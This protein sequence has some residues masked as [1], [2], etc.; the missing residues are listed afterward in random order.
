MFLSIDEFVVC[1][2]KSGDFDPARMSGKQN[3]TKTKDAFGYSL[4]YFDGDYNAISGDTNDASIKP[5]MFSRNTVGGNLKNLYNG[6]IR[7]MTTAIRKNKDE[8]LPVQK[9][10]YSYDQP[11]RIKSMT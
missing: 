6:N 2:S 11:N 3:Q 4:G 8:L 7:Q 1:G 10:N 5:L 9:N